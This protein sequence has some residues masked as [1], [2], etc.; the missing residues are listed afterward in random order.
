MESVGN[1]EVL[2][3]EGNLRNPVRRDEECGHGDGQSG[4]AG[5]AGRLV[6]DRSSFCSGDRKGKDP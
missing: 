1:S 5:G 6:L 3:L 4:L 2:E